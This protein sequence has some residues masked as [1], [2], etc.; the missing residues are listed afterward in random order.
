MDT[1]SS[2]VFQWQAY[3]ASISQL[4]SK[5]KLGKVGGMVQIG[6][7]ISSLVTPVAAGAVMV[8][9]GLPGIIII[10]FVTYLFAVGALSLIRF[11]KVVITEE[12]NASRKALLGEIIIG[13]RYLTARS[14]LM[15]LLILFASINL[16]AG[17]VN[18][19]ILPFLLDL[20]STE[21]AGLISSLMGLGMLLGTL[22]MSVWGGP[23]RRIHGAVGF[24]AVNGFFIMLLGL[25]PSLMLVGFA[26]FCSIFVNPIIGGSSQALWQS[27]VAHEIQGRVF[28]LRRVIAGSTVPIAFL[29]AGWLENNVFGPLMETGGLLA[30]TVGKVIGVGPGRGAGL[31]FILIGLFMILIASGGYLDPRVRKVEVELP[32]AIT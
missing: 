18:V 11:P 2:G 13:W 32:D 6:Y 22:T 17:M 1:N 19:L 9:V 3:S 8:S 24:S 29:L 30:S 12:V 20:T 15:G 7:A 25:N 27:K 31:L 23:K 14:G 21:M 10:D 26:A 28:S 5:E 16:F 4:V